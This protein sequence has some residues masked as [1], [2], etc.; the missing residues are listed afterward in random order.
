LSR[1]IR[2][3]SSRGGWDPGVLATVHCSLKRAIYLSNNANYFGNDV[4][5]SLHLQSEND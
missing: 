5:Y 3:T 4:I 2:E 1:L